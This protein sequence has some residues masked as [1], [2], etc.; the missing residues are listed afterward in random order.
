MQILSNALVDTEVRTREQEGLVEL[1]SRLLIRPVKNEHAGQYQC[2]ASNSLG[3]AYSLKA[4]IV[5]SGE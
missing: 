5:V 3:S 4:E 1:T 2:I